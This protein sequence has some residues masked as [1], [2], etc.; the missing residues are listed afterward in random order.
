MIDTEKQLNGSEESF[1]VLV[2][3]TDEELSS[4]GGGHSTMNYQAP[5]FI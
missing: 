1:P 3:L 2:P 5:L 4:V